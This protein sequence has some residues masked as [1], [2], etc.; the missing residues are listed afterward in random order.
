MDLLTE[1]AKH[2]KEWIRIVKSFG[3]Y[4]YHEDIVQEMYLRAHKYVKAE[5]VI[6]NGKLNK[7]FFWFMLR[8]IH[9]DVCK[10]KSRLDIAPDGFVFVHEES[11]ESKHEAYKRIL[12]KIDEEMDTWHWYDKMLFKLYKDSDMSL[13]DIEKATGISLRSI[14]HTISHCKARINYAVG[15]DYQD[16]KNQEYE[17][18]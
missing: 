14:F 1:I 4:D 5:K 12:F 9:L 17:L 2:H 11:E 6:T 3:E 13:R 10:S 16:Y 18:I 8:N 7:S 15:E